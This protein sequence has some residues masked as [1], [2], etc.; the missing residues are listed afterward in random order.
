MVGEAEHSAQALQDLDY[1]L[2]LTSVPIEKYIDLGYIV[3][4]TPILPNFDDSE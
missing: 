4:P 2:D 3:R 1:G